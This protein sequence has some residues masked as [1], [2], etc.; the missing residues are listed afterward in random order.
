MLQSKNSFVLSLPLVSFFLRTLSIPLNCQ[1]AT[2][3]LTIRVSYSSIIRFAAGRI[4]YTESEQALAFMA[5]A[6]A[7][8]TVLSLSPLYT[9]ISPLC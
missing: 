5:G 6:N 2:K 7:I 3:L 9:S 4:S 8:F 1:L